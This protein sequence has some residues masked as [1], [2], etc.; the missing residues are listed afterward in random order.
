MAKVGPRNDEGVREIN[1][2]TFHY[3]GWTPNEFDEATYVRGDATQLDL[4]PNSHRGCLD[5]DILMKHGCDFDRVREDPLFFY[6]L[7]FPICPPDMSDIEND[8]QM[9]YFSHVATCTNVYASTSGGGIGMGHEW[10]SVNVP[11]LVKWT[12]V[13]LRH[14]ALDGKPGT[15]FTR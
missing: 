13:P 5:V 6:Q 12:A 2:W 8:G 14:G 4:K 7:L 9:P 3:T 1:G 15:L 11:E 10:R